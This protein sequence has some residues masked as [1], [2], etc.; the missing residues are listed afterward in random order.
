MALSG[1]E[2]GEG[3]VPEGVVLGAEVVETLGVADEMEGKGHGEGGV[4]RK[5]W[6]IE[7]MQIKVV[8]EST[9]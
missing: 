3:W 7:D 1:T 8:S 5:R 9:Q 4:G 6:M 2:G